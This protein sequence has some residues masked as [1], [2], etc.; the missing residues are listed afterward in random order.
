MPGICL[1]RV[2]EQ[3]Q[4]TDIMEIKPTKQ[5]PVFTA[6]CDYFGYIEDAPFKQSEVNNC[7]Y[8]TFELTYMAAVNRL[9]EW[10]IDNK[11]ILN[12]YPKAKFR[13]RIMDG[14]LDKYQDAIQ[15]T[16]YTISASKAKKLLIN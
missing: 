3:Q 2:M 15:K 5:S 13:I 4:K 1:F 9:H 16:V 14:T 11:E 8:P 12:D 10:I 6:D 7:I